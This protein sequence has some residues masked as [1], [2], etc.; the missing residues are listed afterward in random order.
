MKKTAVFLIMQIFAA[1][2]AFNLSA[3]TVDISDGEP[4]DAAP[5]TSTI[6]EDPDFFKVESESPLVEKK[7]SSLTIKTNVSGASVYLNGN[8]RGTTPLTIKNLTEG[9]YRL[10]LQKTHYETRELSIQVRRG[11][12]RV[13]YIDLMRIIG[14]LSFIVTPSDATVSCDG[15]TVNE[16]PMTL[17]EGV[18]SIS[19]KKFGYN[20]WTSSVMVYRNMLRRVNIQLDKAEFAITSLSASRTS[21]NPRNAGTLGSTSIKFSVTAPSSG[22]LS[23]TSAS[24][25]VVWYGSYTQFTT[26]NYSATWDGKTNNGLYAPDGIYTATLEASGQSASC[27][28]TID[29]SITYPQLS[30]SYSGTGLGSVASAQLYPENAMLLHFALG[31]AVLL[32]N[33]SFYGAPFTAQFAWA[34]IKQLEFS[35]SYNVMLGELKTASGSTALKFGSK[36]SL[37][38]NMDFAF[39]MN[40]RAGF[41]QDALFAPYGTDIGTGFGTGLL[42]G[43]DTGSFYAGAESEYIY[44][45]IK[46]LFTKGNDR[47]WKNGIMVQYRTADASIGAYGSLMSCFG[48]YAYTSSNESTLC[49]GSAAGMARALDAGLESLIF[50]SGSSVSA[51]LKAGTVWYPAAED[52]TSENTVY[53][54]GMLGITIVF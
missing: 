50:F 10:R 52:T 13:Y 34:I 7:N 21:F 48:T 43:I 46:G 28:F 5:S 16:N 42:F 27:T 40:V 4:F 33:K 23:I 39:A 12:E 24:G 51:D 32:N 22:K 20:T 3:E 1:T 54:Y 11:Q 30:V 44:G 36:V 6:S 35:A 49:E 53:L 29:S 26:W 15:F 14:K 9:K 45:P 17:D 18:H 47:A 31:P 37:N 2:V 25:T 38:K 8:Y 41:T 19:V